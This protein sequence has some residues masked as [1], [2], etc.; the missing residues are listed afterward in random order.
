MKKIICLLVIALFLCSTC[1]AATGAD[2]LNGVGNKLWRGVVNTF[3]GWIEFPAQIYKGYERGF[4]GNENNKIG[5]AFVGIFTGIGH[6][7]GRTLS[8]LGD[9]AGFWAADPANNDGVGIPLDAEYAWEE[10]TVYNMFDPNFGEGALNPMGNKLGRGIGDSLGGFLEFP[11]QIVKGIKLGAPDL[12]IVKGLWYWYSRQ[13]DGAFD[14]A[15]FFLPNPKDTK[16]LPF[17]EKWPWS[18]LG[19]SMKKETK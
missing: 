9:V 11:G 10:G 19:D 4:N 13:V 8:G 1:Y 3:T 6:T 7:A 17:D 12:G 5:G 18:A 15:G 2:Y 16:A 14:I